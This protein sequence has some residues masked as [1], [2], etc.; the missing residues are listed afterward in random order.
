MPLSVPV[1]SS[2]SAG[3][4]SIL[5]II[6]VVVLLLLIVL[7]ALAVYHLWYRKRWPAVK[8]KLPC[9]K[10]RSKGQVDPQIDNEDIRSSQAP[11]DASERPLS[12]QKPVRARVRA[13]VCVCVCARRRACVRACV[14]GGWGQVLK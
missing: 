14:E 7:A 4:S 12:G 8:E 1:P 11:A 10:G 5:V 13:R 9:G 6:V 3:S 2:A